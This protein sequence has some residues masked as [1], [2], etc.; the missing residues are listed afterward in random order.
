MMGKRVIVTG[1]VGRLVA[2]AW[3]L[4]AATSCVGLTANGTLV[5][6]ESPE[7]ALQ[8]SAAKPEPPGTGADN[9]GAD[10]NGADEGERPNARDAEHGFPDPPQGEPAPR[11]E[12][13]TF[14]SAIRGSQSDA[15][16]HL[17][18][19]TTTERDEWEEIVFT[20]AG[21]DNVP[22][23]TVD[24]SDAVRPH[25]EADPL[26]LNGETFLTVDFTRTDPSSDGQMQ[27]PSD[28][29]PGYPQISEIVLA[30]NVGGDLRFGIGLTEENG[31]VT[32]E[33][34]SPTRLVIQVAT[35]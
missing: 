7:L 33:L 5:P 12:P 16:G 35:P 9:N 29:R 17:V 23:Y 18:G 32:Q 14:S 30:H 27:I 28:L 22:S 13:D 1:R 24:Y 15:T 19:V 10:D 11:P 34:T 31:F 3:L 26:P 4:A 20:F 6:P 8:S 2:V 21:T 25:D